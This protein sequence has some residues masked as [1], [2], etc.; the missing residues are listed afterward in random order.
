MF[1]NVWKLNIF[2][3]PEADVAP[4]W[5]SHGVTGSRRQHEAAADVQDCAFEVCATHATCTWTC[6]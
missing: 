4:S 1:L 6:G 2:Q 5:G 3:N